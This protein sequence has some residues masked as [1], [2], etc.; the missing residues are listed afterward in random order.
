MR[1][2]IVKLTGAVLLTWAAVVSAQS[3]SVPNRND[4]AVATEIEHR[5]SDDRDV[6]AQQIEID[7]RDGV[8]TLRGSTPDVAAKTRAGTLAAAVPGVVDVQNDIG[9]G[10][11]ALREDVTPGTIPE[12][13]PG[14]R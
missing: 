2:S 1:T 9:V 14:A 3:P 13:M 5:L 7:V 8:V 6:N 12:E 4:T 10:H 11:P